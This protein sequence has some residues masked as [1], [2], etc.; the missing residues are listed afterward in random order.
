MVLGMTFNSGVFIGYA[1]YAD[2]AL[3]TC[4]PFYL[5]G[6]LWT[7]VYDTIYAFQDREFDKKLGLRST[8]IEIEKRPK[9]SLAAM[10][11]V[12]T[13]LFALG[14]LNAGIMNPVYGAGM[15]GVAAHYYWQIST[16]DIE[17]RENCWNRFESNKW[18]GLMLFGTIVGAKAYKARETD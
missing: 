10:A 17:N 12:S 7:M 18:L 8:A 2:L 15:A 13:A 5:G 14:G 4:M 1:A 9:E 6:V 3:S 16:M 11:S